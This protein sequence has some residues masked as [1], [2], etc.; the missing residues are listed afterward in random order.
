MESPWNGEADSLSRYPFPTVTE[1]AEA[2]K[3]SHHPC[4]VVKGCIALVAVLA[5]AES[6][7]NSVAALSSAPE[8]ENIK[9]IIIDDTLVKEMREE[10]H[11][12]GQP[13]DH[14]RPRKGSRL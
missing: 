2:E 6:P 13:Y 11:T 7:L 9:Q 3:T 12:I 8:P 4:E 1:C 14:A 10:M 5:R